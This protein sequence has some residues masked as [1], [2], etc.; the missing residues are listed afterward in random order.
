M[1]RSASSRWLDHSPLNTTS[2]PTGSPAS[3]RRSSVAGGSARTPVIT[4]VPVASRSKRAVCSSSEPMRSSETL[5]SCVHPEG[6]RRSRTS[7]RSSALRS[8]SSR[9][10]TN[11]SSSCPSNPR[12]CM[13]AVLVTASFRRGR[14]PCSASGSQTKSRSS[15]TT[16][17]RA[18]SGRSLGSRA[19]RA[20]R[21]CLPSSGAAQDSMAA[22]RLPPSSA[23]ES[24]NSN[25]SAV[26][27]SE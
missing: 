8:C 27:P 11:A 25:R 24:G 14:G 16:A 21:K 6:E 4:R 20:R 19:M 3:R 23:R 22:S 17:S 5:L 12:A 2:C 26:T 18:V 7:A 10:R 13:T 9:R 1:S 15:S